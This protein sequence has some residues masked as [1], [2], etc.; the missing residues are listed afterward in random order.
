MPPGRLLDLV[1]VS[2]LADTQLLRV[3]AYPPANGGAL[4]THVTTSIA[5]D[6]PLAAVTA[7]R[8][9]LRAGLVANVIGADPPGRRLLDTLDRAGIR[10]TVAAIPGAATPALIVVVDAHGTRTWFASLH[11]AAVEV[12]TA[13]LHLLTD[14]RLIYVDC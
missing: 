4:V 5:A 14:T 13:N 2:Y 6:G 7:A 8:L 3:S 1:C 12:A 10:H 11:D 9:G